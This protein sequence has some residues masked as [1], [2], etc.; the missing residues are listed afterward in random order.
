MAKVRSMRFTHLISVLE[1]AIS[2]MLEAYLLG[3]VRIETGGTEAEIPAQGSFVAAFA[4]HSGWIESVVI[5]DCF[6]I[7]GRTWPT[8]LTKEENRSLPRFI[9]GDR[10]ICVDRDTPEPGVMRTI[11]ALLQ[12]PNAVLATAFEG[13]RLGNPQDPEDLVTLSAFKPGPVR[14]ASRAQVPV[15]P[16][17][18]LGA[19]RVVPH[20][21]RVW[22][23]QGM[24]A[25]YRE[26]HLKRA[27]PQP[28][29]VHVLPLY[30]GHLAE[31]FSRGK[32]QRESADRHTRI[33]HEMLAARI[34]ELDPHYP[35]GST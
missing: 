27:E 20:L 28:I 9:T 21:D 22:H 17:V 35:L 31:G 26:I 23:R 13:T 19:E 32:R 30:R 6:R 25:A 12:Q 34:R 16:I 2:R 8:W 29:R 4:P 15:L 5:D 24:F 18:V 1:N 10:A 11:Y 7:A 3:T 14:I 33:L